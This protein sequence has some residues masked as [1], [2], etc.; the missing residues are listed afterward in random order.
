VA[1]GEI[2][3]QARGFGRS[4]LL[5]ADGKAII[6]DEDGH[7]ALARLSPTGHEVLARAQIFSGTAWTVPALVGTTLFARDRE[8][9]VALDLAQR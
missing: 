7:L 2:A 4:S 5:Y 3:W 8:R 6:L 9:I 1:T